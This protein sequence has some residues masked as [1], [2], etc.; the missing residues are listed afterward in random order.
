MHTVEHGV[1]RL[2]YE[3]EEVY[4][5]PGVCLIALTG[6]GVPNL[7]ITP[8]GVENVDGGVGGNGAIV[9]ENGLEQAS[10][11]AFP[12][13]NPNDAR[14]PDWETRK[15][16]PV[17]PQLAAIRTIVRPFGVHYVTYHA[18]LY[19]NEPT[20]AILSIRGPG[21]PDLDIKREG[22]AVLPHEQNEL[23]F[24]QLNLR[25]V[26]TRKDLIPS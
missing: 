12:V 16:L 5:L 21:M 9:F 3:F 11:M 25:V 15:R 24:G 13:F 17:D 2:T 1:H 19:R 23:D 22:V 14:R 26:I 4:G 7:H 8:R 20:V 18:G 10:R 6:P